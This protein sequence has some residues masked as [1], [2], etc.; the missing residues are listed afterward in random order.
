MDDETSGEE[1]EEVTAQVREKFK[2][3]ADQV[4][5][6][7]FAIRDGARWRKVNY[8]MDIAS[9]I[10]W[11]RADLSPLNS[12]NLSMLEEKDVEQVA[13]LSDDQREV[14]KLRQS[15]LLKAGAL[16]LDPVFLARHLLD[17][18]PNPWIAYE[19]GK[20]LLNK[21]L[22]KFPEKVVINNFVFIIEELRKHLAGEKDRLAEKV[23]RDMISQ[24]KMHFLV[25]ANKLGYKLLKPKPK[26][27]TAPYLTKKTAAPLER[28]LFDPVSADDFNET[29]RQVAWYLDDQNKLLF[30]YRNVPKEDY[31]VQGWQKHRVYAD[32]IFTDTNSN[33]NGFNR[34]FVVETKGLH[35][36]DADRTQYTTKLF[37]LCNERAREMTLT[38]LGL[39]LPAK[40]ISF[41]VIAE[42]E[43]QN[44]FNAL[45][46]S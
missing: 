6:P 15:E 16:H 14:I 17:I 41:L 11:D 12:L 43:W 21:L 44:R 24:D 5:L 29:E 45:F 19:F 27:V 34:V 38:E 33:S 36:K 32:F 7:V 4:I 40:Q 2:K 39:K 25:I 26:K 20:T 18:V 42:D 22:T 1:H 23:F 46:V 13:T 3:A 28:S 31:G 30:W 35:L 8:D 37:N 9:Q 10:P